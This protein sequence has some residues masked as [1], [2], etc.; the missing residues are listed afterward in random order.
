MKHEFNNNFADRTHNNMAV[1]WYMAEIIIQNN[2]EY[3]FIHKLKKR[4]L[5][6]ILNH[7]NGIAD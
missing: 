2:M 1:I 5:N 7:T 3:Y 6:I 4:L